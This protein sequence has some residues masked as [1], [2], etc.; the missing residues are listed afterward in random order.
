M[1]E[2]GLGNQKLGLWA[3]FQPTSQKGGL[4]LRD[5]QN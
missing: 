5:P 2:I 3:E 4:E 1:T